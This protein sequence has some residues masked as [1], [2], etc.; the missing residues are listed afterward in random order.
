M[1]GSDKICIGLYSMKN[2]LE[3]NEKIQ[4][5]IIIVIIIVIIHL[6]KICSI[7]CYWDQIPS[8]A[9]WKSDQFTWSS[10]PL[11][12]EFGGVGTYRHSDV[13]VSKQKWWRCTYEKEYLIL[14][15]GHVFIDV[16]K[17]SLDR[18][19]SI[20]AIDLDVASASR[21]WAGSNTGLGRSLN[22]VGRL[23]QSKTK[24][25]QLI[26][27]QFLTNKYSIFIH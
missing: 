26:H 24:S 15:G 11:R 25:I 18:S 5:T 12:L 3:M 23:A 20:L 14:E 1:D 19:M 17:G 27:L 16:E 9:W 7:L 4:Y 10:L 21:C 22:G 13:N 2:P 8:F 6:I